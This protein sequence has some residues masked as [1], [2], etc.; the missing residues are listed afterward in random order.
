MVYCYTQQLPWTPNYDRCRIPP[1]EIPDPLVCF[2]GSRVT[3]PEE[4]FSKRRPELIA[5]Y[6]KYFYGDEL[7]L[8]DHTEYKLLDEKTI[9]NGQGIRRQIELKF[10]MKNGREH[11][12]IMLVYLPANKKDIPVF[13]G[14]NFVGNHVVEA[15]PD[16]I[17]TGEIGDLAAER[18]S[19]SRRYPL[20]LILGSGYA[21]ATVTHHEFYLDNHMN[22]WENSVCSKL[23]QLDP[24][25]YSAIGTW[26]WGISRMLDCLTDFV[27]EI[28]PEKAIVYGHSRLGKTS[29]WTMARDT[30]FKM[31]CVNDS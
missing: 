22:G 16:I 10:S 17:P 12:V 15:D 31:A 13:I 27:P 26:S 4:W 29:L 5:A 1:F 19:A 2:D 11:K 18:G 8:P 3:T 28:D 21:I 6:R 30:R 9:L 14:L 7:P 25:N 24:Q 23:F 20:E